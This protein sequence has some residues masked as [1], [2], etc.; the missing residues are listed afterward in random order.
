MDWAPAEVRD[1]DVRRRCVVGLSERKQCDREM[2][3]CF[4]WLITRRDEADLG[5]ALLHV[6]TLIP[7]RQM[8]A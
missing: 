6:M 7:L 2:T 1:D 3:L 8:L 4:R 5:C